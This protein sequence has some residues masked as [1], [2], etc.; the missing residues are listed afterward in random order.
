V[1]YIFSMA[2][3][4]WKWAGISDHNSKN[5]SIIGIPGIYTYSLYHC[6]PS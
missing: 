4:G 3:D 2:L 1:A 5:V 6:L